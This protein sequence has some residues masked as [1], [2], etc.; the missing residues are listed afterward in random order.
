VVQVIEH[1]PSKCEALSSNSSIGKK[2]KIVYK[3]K[4]ERIWVW[5]CVFTH[6]FACRISGR[7]HRDSGCRQKNL[8][9]KRM[10]SVLGDFE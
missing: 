10:N 7:T 4:G 9:Q 3:I 8:R 1:L 6:L 5:E 2:K